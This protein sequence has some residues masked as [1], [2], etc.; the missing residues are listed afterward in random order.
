MLAAACGQDE[1]ALIDALEELWQRRIIR[2]QGV[3]AYDFS[4]DKLRDVAYSG[5]SPMQRRRLHRRVAQ[6]LQEIYAADLDAVR[7]QLAAHYGQAGLAETAVPHY[8]QAALVATRLLAYHEAIGH[9]QRGLALLAELPETTEHQQQT[10]ALLM[11]LGP[12]WAATKGNA[13]AQVREVYTRALALCRHVGNKRQTFVV[14]QELRIGYGQRG[15]VAVAR[16]LAQENLA[17]AQELASPELLRY[18]QLGMAVVCHTQAELDLAL[19]YFEQGI[20]QPVTHYGDSESLFFDSALQGSL[21]HSALTLW[22]SG[23]P[24]QARVR[25]GEALALGRQN[26]QSI[27]YAMTIIFAAMLHHYLGEVQGVQ[28]RAQELIRLATTYGFAYH[29]AS[30][31]MFEGWVQAR[32]GMSAQGTVQLRQNLEVRKVSGHRLFF[33]YELG[34]LGEAYLL[35]G[36]A[37]AG[38]AAL[39]DALAVADQTGEYV[40]QAELL[41]LQAEALLAQAAPLGEIEARYLQAIELARRQKARSLELRASVGLARLWQ[42]AGRSSDARQLLAPIYAWFTEGFDTPDLREAGA[43]LQT[44]QNSA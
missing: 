39:Q 6:A 8:Q 26:A 9:L 42:H 41:R 22:L 12:L 34:L 2:E 18:A 23:Y 38:L 16:Q 4:H 7:G 21:R 33:P 20:S 10:L 40:W 43:L 37:A 27:R 13:A 36:E 17:L 25:I 14:Q 15:E 1:D 32:Q 30:G 19:M 29:L 24:E 31:L 11:A 5:I 28:L 35:G 44:L 3:N